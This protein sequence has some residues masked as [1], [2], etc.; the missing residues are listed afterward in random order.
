MWVN[1]MLHNNSVFQ[2]VDPT[3]EFSFSYFE[4]QSSSDSTS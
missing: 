4:L 3:Q 1:L 2:E